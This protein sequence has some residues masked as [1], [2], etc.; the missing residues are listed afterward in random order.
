MELRMVI[1]SSAALAALVG[2]VLGSG[3]LPQHAAAHSLHLTLE[4]GFPDQPPLPRR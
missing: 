4:I 3:A 2:L 1:R